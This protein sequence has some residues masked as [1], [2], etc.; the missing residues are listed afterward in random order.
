MGS[1]RW[2][3]TKQKVVQGW[4]GAGI[5]EGINVGG[6][7]CVSAVLKGGPNGIQLGILAILVS[8]E[9]VDVPSE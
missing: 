4:G 3:G 2:K 7:W 9:A 6:P 5:V 1:R 8:E